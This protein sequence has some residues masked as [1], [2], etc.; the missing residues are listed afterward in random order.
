M[1]QAPSGE[2]TQYA[3]LMDY[4]TVQ[5]AGTLVHLE[6]SAGNDI[7]TF[8]PAKEYQSLLL[9][10][11]TLQEGETYTLYAGG[12]A[13]GSTVDGV[14][15]EQTYTGGTEVTDFTISDMITYLNR[16]G[17][18]GGDHFGQGQI[19]DDQGQGGPMNGGGR[20]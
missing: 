10:S 6:D 14:Y 5:Q 7:L 1:A 3:V 17:A 12:E 4:D 13:T 8:A 19:P 20:R 16:S 11:P 15:R 18:T 2:S 9:C